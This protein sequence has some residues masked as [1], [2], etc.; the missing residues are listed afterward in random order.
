VI[1]LRQMNAR[2]FGHF[3]SFWTGFNAFATAPVRPTADR[4]VAQARNQLRKRLRRAATR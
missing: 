1:Q 2:T 4:R 3:L